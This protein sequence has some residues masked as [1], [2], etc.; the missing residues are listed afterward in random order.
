[1]EEAKIKL[2]GALHDEGMT[3]F[4]K[5]QRGLRP[6]FGDICRGRD[7]VATMQKAEGQVGG[8]EWRQCVQL[9]YIWVRKSDSKPA[10]SHMVV[11]SPVWLF[12]QGGNAFYF[13][14]P[15]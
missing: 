3:E 11:A 15:A 7:T 4:R 1:M 10:L 12:L 14:F 6:G 9:R 5:R 8:E 2:V 13:F